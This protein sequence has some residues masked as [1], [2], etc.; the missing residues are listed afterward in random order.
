ML[1]GAKILS[2]YL[3]VFLHLFN[4]VCFSQIQI[5][6]HIYSTQFLRKMW[7][8]QLAFRLLTSCRILLSSWIPSNTILFLTWSVHLFFFHPLQHLLQGV[9]KGKIQGGIQVTGRWG[10][11]FS[12]KIMTLIQV[13]NCVWLNLFHIHWHY[14]HSSCWFDFCNCYHW[15]FV[16]YMFDSSIWTSCSD[17]L[18]V[19]GFLE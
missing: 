6:L 13:Q 5:R 19:I 10:R 2:K 16:S 1:K 18:F 12:V 3:I 8:I 7:P 14:H 15:N 4:T 9:I 17:S 11:K